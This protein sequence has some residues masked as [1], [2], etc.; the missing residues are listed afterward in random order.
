MTLVATFFE[1][2]DFPVYIPILI[3]YFCYMAWQVAKRQKEHMNKYGYGIKDFFVKK[4]LTEEEKEL[5][6]Q[7]L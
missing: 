4:E 6:Q 5:K 2:F 7:R 1:V 3:I